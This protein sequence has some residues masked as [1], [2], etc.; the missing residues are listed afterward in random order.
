MDSEKDP[1]MTQEPQLDY[2]IRRVLAPNRGAWVM[3]IIFA[4]LFFIPWSVALMH[5]RSTLQKVTFTTQDHVIL[6]GN[7]YAPRSPD[8]I[9][10]ILLHGLGSVKEEWDAFVGLL[11][12]HGY[13]ILVYDARGH[14]KSQEETS[15]KAVNYQSFYGTGLASQ[16][17]AMIQDLDIAVQFL[18]KRYNIRPKKIAIGGASIGA[19]FALRYAVSHPEIPYVFLLSP[20]VNYQGITTH[21]VI[22]DYG[23]RPVFMAASLQDQYSYKSVLA[24]QS[25]AKQETKVTVYIE[26]KNMGHGVQMFKR[27]DP[28]K[29]SLL[30]TQLLRWLSQQKK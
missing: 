5:A 8:Q 25:S 7:Y 2:G 21:N 28:L 24:L 29:P 11:V 16:W 4:T 22:Q 30:E 19:N 6:H 23:R 13:G 20:G 10:L 1:I 12:D 9:T 17:G 15:G 14:G 18:E 3:K 26:S 27:D